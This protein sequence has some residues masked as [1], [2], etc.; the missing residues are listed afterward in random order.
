MLCFWGEALPTSTALRH[1]HSGGEGSNETAEKKITCLDQELVDSEI[2]IPSL[3]KQVSKFSNVTG[4]IEKEKRD[5]SDRNI[6]RNVK[7]FIEHVCVS[8]SMERASA[9]TPRTPAV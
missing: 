3:W 2:K 4:V 1:S 6:D 8:V 9:P 7:I 5:F